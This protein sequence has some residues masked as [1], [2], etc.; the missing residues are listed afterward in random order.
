[1]LGWTYL[2]IQ[3][4]IDYNR[5]HITFPLL[6]WPRPCTMYVFGKLRQ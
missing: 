6:F 2:N 5:F 1:M 3:F 4:P